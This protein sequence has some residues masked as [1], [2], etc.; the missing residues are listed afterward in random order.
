MK[1]ILL[2]SCA[3]LASAAVTAWAAD[4]KENY[5]K[6]CS[7][8]HGKDGKGDTKMG[9]KLGAKDY[10]DPKVQDALTDEAAF[11]ATK[12]G[13]KDKDGKVLMKPSEGK[14]DDEIKGLFAYMRTFKKK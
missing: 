6:A 8:C 1:K 9:Q 10:T 2:V 11:K 7:K 13:F 14:S 5:E 12:D 3:L 4:A